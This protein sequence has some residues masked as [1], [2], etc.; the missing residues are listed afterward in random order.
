MIVVVFFRVNFKL[1][2]SEDPKGVIGPKVDER[3]GNRAQPRLPRGRGL[4]KHIA[5][6]VFVSGVQGKVDVKP[7][8]LG[9]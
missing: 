4:E 2:P 7:I 1:D 8:E 9:W 5:D 6:E 3:E